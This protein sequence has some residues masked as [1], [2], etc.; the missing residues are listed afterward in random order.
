MHNIS[1][2]SQPRPSPQPLLERRMSLKKVVP[3]RM[4]PTGKP[5]KNSLFSP[6]PLPKSKF[7]PAAGPGA[8][9]EKEEEEEEE[10]KSEGKDESGFGPLL[11]VPPS[12]EKLRKLKALVEQKQGGSPGLRDP[13]VRRGLPSAAIPPKRRISDL[14]MRADKAKAG[15][16]R[17]VLR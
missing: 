11:G 13:K 7:S 1:I 15:A 12:P 17:V 4:T 9:S 6:V 8:E 10:E 2:D 16:A 3:E 14:Q 5:R